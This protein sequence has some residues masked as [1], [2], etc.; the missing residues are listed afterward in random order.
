MV[1]FLEFEEVNKIIKD[2]WT[3]A[4]AQGKTKLPP[5]AAGHWSVTVYDEDSD[6]HMDGPPL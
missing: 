3:S 1:S 2:T 5:S 4:I 6:E